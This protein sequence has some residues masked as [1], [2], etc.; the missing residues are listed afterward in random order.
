MN[1]AHRAPAMP[2]RA[3]RH[4]RPPKRRW[5]LR[6][7]VVLTTL[8]VL[9]VATAAGSESRTALDAGALDAAQQLVLVV[10]VVGPLAACYLACVALWRTYAA[11]RTAPRHR[12]HV[13]GRRESP[14]LLEQRHPRCRGD[15][16]LA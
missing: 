7:L 11:D 15:V 6:A 16:Q 3:A 13:P 9:L 14:D 4:R 2:R 8:S 10:L 1:G 12:S 5:W